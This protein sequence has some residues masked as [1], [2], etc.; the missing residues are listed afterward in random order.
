MIFESYAIVALSCFVGL[1]ILD[2]SS[3]GLSVQSASCI[4]FT[5]FLA[6][7]FSQALVFAFACSTVFTSSLADGDFFAALRS[8][9]MLAL[10]GLSMAAAFS[11]LASMAFLLIACDSITYFLSLAAEPL[12]MCL[13]LS[14]STRSPL[15]AD[16]EQD[17][18][19]PPEH[20]PCFRPFARRA[21]VV[22]TL[23][24]VNGFMRAAFS[25]AWCSPT[26]SAIILRI[27]GSKRRCL[28]LAVILAS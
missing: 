20:R 5:V 18:T 10:Q 23:L 27:L 15:L 14:C 7:A 25:I 9:C 22:S 1:Q 17:E 26:A 21:P 28:C 6:S 4:F 13:A 11:Q 8:L 12:P 24:R 19:Q 16:V 2:F 3:T